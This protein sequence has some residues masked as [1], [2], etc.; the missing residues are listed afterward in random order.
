MNEQN[1]Q[2][3]MNTNKR[4]NIGIDEEARYRLEA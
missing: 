1:M 2:D 4:K 3:T